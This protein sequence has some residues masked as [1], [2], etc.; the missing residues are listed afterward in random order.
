[1]HLHAGVLGLE[2]A[3]KFLRASSPILLYNFPLKDF[4]LPTMLEVFN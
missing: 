3:V 2:V 4:E 1:M